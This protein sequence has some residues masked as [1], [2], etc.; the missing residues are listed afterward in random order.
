MSKPRTN[1]RREAPPSGWSQVTPISAAVFW[2][3]L[4]LLAI[5]VV[6]SAFLLSKHFGGALPGCG[7]KSGCEAL[8]SS[9]WG[10]VPGIH[11]PVSFLGFAYFL[12]LLAGLLVSGR[13]VPTR[14]RW[15]LRLGAVASLIF[16]GVM[17]A[18][19]KL[20]PYCVGAHAANLTLVILMEW[21]LRLPG[22]RP[23]GAGASIPWARVQRIAGA[24]VAVFVAAS[25]V[26]GLS[27]ARLQRQVR[28][29]AEA[30]RQASTE[31]ILAQSRAADVTAN[32]VPS[33]VG[34]R[35]AGSD[36]PGAPGDPAGA[37]PASAAN[38][39]AG[40]DRPAVTSPPAG[41][42]EAAGT[43]RPAVA[44][45]PASASGTAEPVPPA[46]P[47]GPTGKGFTGRYRHGPEASPIR[48]V[49]LTDYQCSDCRRV[50][51]ELEGILASRQD[52]SVSIKHYPFCAEAAPGVPCNK[53]LKQ[54]MHPNACWAAR[55]AE[56]AGMLR[57]DEGFW[58]MHTWLFAR[59]GSFTDAELSAALAQMD[60]PA[61][62]FLAAMQGPETL[63]RVQADCDEG[64]ALGLYF[65]PMI[66]VN[67]VEFKGWQ[68]PGALK[69]T[70]EEVA[71]T[72]PPARTAVA[73]RPVPASQKDI[74]DWL[75]Q[76]VRVLAAD[77]RA[78]SLGA[79]PA[80]SRFVNVVVFGDYQ[81]PYTSSMDRAIR[82]FIK[83]KPGFRYTFRHYPIDPSS[84]PTLPAQVRREAIHPLAGR[85]AKAAEAAGSIAGSDGYWKM[86]AWLMENL[87]SF[88]DENLRAAAGKMGIDPA[89]LFSE[90]EK[91][92]VMAAIAEDARAAQQIGL[93]AVPM[94]FVNGRWVQRSIRDGQ[95]VV[96]PIMERA[97]AM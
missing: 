63:R 65:T 87:T 9:P 52:V 58:A 90:M 81:E 73:D 14:I 57:G 85:A 19:R 51:G 37:R 92:E 30:E 55:A 13:V 20:C 67:G 42:N 17:I 16:V 70:I 88:T 72:N 39:A 25:L 34:P 28:A 71:A 97:A 1:G 62:A 89:R 4:L 21:A 79:P 96:L 82:Q 7:P 64:T 33:A 6:L 74:E 41:A 69:R 93:T 95:N 36:D 68:V 5:A 56:A 8:E 86:H 29:R 83:G 76:P 27:D 46:T 66:F 26:L 11:W 31:R 54:T 77:T 35:S 49:M 48:I 50:E 91:P 40:T 47:P 10:A 80:G 3:G 22:A 12:A 60:L 44:N 45:P 24:G 78:W 53:Y 75:A 94:V 84:N 61:E 23:A 32:P 38:E 43:D 15:L 18:Y 59:G 2:A